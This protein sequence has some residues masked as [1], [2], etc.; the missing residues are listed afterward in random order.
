MAVTY[1]DAAARWLWSRGRV[2]EAMRWF[3]D[4]ARVGYDFPGAHLNAATA[5]AA[6]GKPELALEELLTAC[7]LAPYAAEP[8]AR[9][10]V[11]L[12]ATERPR[13]A[14]LWFERAF[15]T[16]PS[17]A[18]AADACRAWTRAGDVERA[19]SWGRR[20]AEW[21]EPPTPA[22]SLAGVRG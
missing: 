2:H 4:A 6:A 3:F 14:A 8:K 5:A 17:R 19:E 20:A 9:L 1:S 7:R 22:S 10:A 21:S 15:R 13:D 11:F 12:A 16:E 18:L